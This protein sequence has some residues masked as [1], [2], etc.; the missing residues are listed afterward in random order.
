MPRALHCLTAADILPLADYEA[1]RAAERARIIALKA[2]RRV[3]VG[4][5]ATFYF[6]NYDTMW[7][8]VQEMLRIERG[9]PAQIEDELSAYNP[10][11]PKGHELVATLMFEIDEPVARDRI[12]RELTGVEATVFLEIGA[13]RIAAAPEHD[14]ER[15]KPDGKT[16]SVHFVR[17]PFTAFQERAFRESAERVLLGIGHKRYPHMAALSPETRAALTEDFA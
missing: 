16:S 8:Q 11:I 10:L 15:T 9:G 14:V 4:P 7:L 6:E 2:L 13:E 12:L 3:E 5:F 1:V 17:F